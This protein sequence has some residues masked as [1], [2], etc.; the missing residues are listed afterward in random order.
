MTYEQ[1][2]TYLNRDNVC[3]KF[4]D[5][6]GNDENQIMN[7]SILRNADAFVIVY[8]AIQIGSIRYYLN[9]Y[10]EQIISFLWY[11]LYVIKLIWLTN[12]VKNQLMKE[13]SL[14]KRIVFTF[15]K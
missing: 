14:Q 9:K 15:L 7:D 10:L 13:E 1:H 4:Y 3:F 6:G 2:R 11:I 8:N 5:I 12:F